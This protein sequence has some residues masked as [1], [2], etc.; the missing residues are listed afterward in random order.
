MGKDQT[1]GRGQRDRTW[2]SS[3]ENSLTFSIYKTYEHFS[4]AHTFAISAAVAVGIM[5]ALHALNIQNL[6]IKWPNDIMA[7]NKKIAGILIENIFKQGRFKSV[8]YRDWAKYQ[9]NW[10][11]KG[12]PN[13][14][15]LAA[16]QQTKNGI[17]Q[18]LVFRTPKSRTR[19]S[20]FFPWNRLSK[21]TI[22]FQTTPRLLWRKDKSD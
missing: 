18:H 22:D 16:E 3:F 4:S 12:L 1:S 19:K 11:F 20:H 21:E 9:S 5:N 7:E 15:S 2:V 6:S 17:S 14:T 13:A 10:N 8:H